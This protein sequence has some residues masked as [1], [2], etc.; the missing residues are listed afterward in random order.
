MMLFAD[1][2]SPDRC[3]QRLPRFRSDRTIICT[4]KRLLFRPSGHHLRCARPTGRPMRPRRPRRR[5]RRLRSRDRR[6]GPSAR[7]HSRAAGGGGGAAAG[8]A[9]APARPRGRADRGVARRAASL[10]RHSARHSQGGSGRLRLTA[11]VMT[12]VANRSPPCALLYVRLMKSLRARWLVRLSRGGWRLMLTAAVDCRRLQPWV[13]RSLNDN[14][15]SLPGLP[16]PRRL[17]V[18]SEALLGD[19]R[20]PDK[21]ALRV[22]DDFSVR[23]DGRPL[24][25][26]SRLVGRIQIRESVSGLDGRSHGSRAVT[27]SI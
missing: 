23:L 10:G 9:M 24:I 27:P 8:G 19:G 22:H 4:A 20:G 16:S 14:A 11:A 18:G 1:L 13:V 2:Q 17:L 5:P 6:V 12:T 26:L 3:A 7:E 21:W 25:G 15:S